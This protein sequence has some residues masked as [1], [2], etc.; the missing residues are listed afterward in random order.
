[1]EGDDRSQFSRSQ[2]SLFVL[3]ASELILI[4]AIRQPQNMYFGSFAFCDPGSNLTLQFLVSHGYRPAVDF[5][6]PYGLLPILIGRL[7]FA[8]FG[9]TPYSYQAAI[10]FGDLI[11]A[12]ALAAVVAR[13]RLGAIGLAIAIIALGFAV[14]TMYPALTHAV[15][16]VLLCCALAEQARGARSPALAFASAAIFAKPSMGYVYSALLVLLIAHDLWRAD[17]PAKRWLHAF[18]P[19]AITS[20]A[21]AALLTLIYGP[22]P[23]ARTILPLEGLATYRNEH[24]GVLGSGRQFWDPG[25]S[26]LYYIVDFAGFWLLGGVF[27]IVCG[28][29]AMRQMSRAAA[30]EVSRKQEIVVTCALLHLAF[31]MVFFGN[32]W[33]W[34]YYSYFLVIGVAAAADG[35][36]Q[37]RKRIARALCVLALTSWIA[38]GFFLYRWWTTM[39]PSAVTA[40]LWATAD[41]RGEWENVIVLAK[42]KRAVLLDTKGAAEL[43]FGVFEAP[44]TMYLDFGLMKPREIQRKLA[45]IA[46]AQLVV[47]PVGGEPPC[48]GVPAGPFQNALARFSPVLKGK[49]FDAY[50]APSR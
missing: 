42:G 36:G 15:E 12:W 34:I 32:Q 21:L 11:I 40:G 37:L 46:G 16:A 35:G 5:G 27:L 19:A 22:I 38:P 49:F 30:V 31:V 3:F 17:A 14:Q 6:Y 8:L 48:F 2:F 7:W 41:E 23:F 20:G 47:V 10:L 9:A 13:L 43:M 45:Q 50:E 39:A 24:F 44:T 18:A 26:W 33:S 29:L 25:L 4:A 1:M 28:A